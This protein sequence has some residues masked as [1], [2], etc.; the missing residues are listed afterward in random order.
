MCKFSQIQK[1]LIHYWGGESSNQYFWGKGENFLADF[2]KFL[3]FQISI[4][5]IALVSLP[6]GH[7]LTFY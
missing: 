7:I 3:L 1:T 4:V 5:D 6:W 2:L